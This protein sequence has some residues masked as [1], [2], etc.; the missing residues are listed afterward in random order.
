MYKDSRYANTDT[1][2]LLSTKGGMSICTNRTSAGWRQANLFKG[3][4]VIQLGIF[5]EEAEIIAEE[6]CCWNCD[7]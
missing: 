4:K 7:K 1:G 3:F 6:N 2:K 5:E